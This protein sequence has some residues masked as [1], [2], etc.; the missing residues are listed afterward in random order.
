MTSLGKVIVPVSNHF[1]WIMH[2]YTHCYSFCHVT[3]K[4]EQHWCVCV[5]VYFTGI[6]CCLVYQGMSESSGPQT[7]N[8]YKVKEKWRTGSCGPRVIGAHIKIENPDKDGNGEVTGRVNYKASYGVGNPQLS[9]FNP[10][11]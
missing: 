6:V 9:L 7:I 11:N 4:P 8:V 10:T 5:C 3:I 1:T 2:D